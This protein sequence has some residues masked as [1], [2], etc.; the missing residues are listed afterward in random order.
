MGVTYRR[1]REEEIPATIDLFLTALTDYTRRHGLA[2]PSYT[3]AD[4]TP[5]YQ[6]LFSTGIFEVAEE[7]GRIVTICSAIVRDDLWFLSMFWALPELRG[8]GIGRPL[9]ERVFAEGKRRGAT[10]FSTWSSLDS[11]AVST[12]LKLGMFPGG[13]ILTFTGAPKQLPAPSAAVRLAPFEAD[14]ADRIDRA[15]RGATRPVDHAYFAAQGAR[16]FQVDAGRGPIGYFYV[17]GGVIG[18]AAWLE[19][20]HGR[21]VLS[22]ALAQASASDAEIK[23]IA[24]GVNE[25]AL[26][27][28]LECGL[29][30]TGSAQ[31]LRSEPFGEPD[32]YVPSGP[33]LF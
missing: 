24:L 27:V 1:V 19:P 14:V 10:R 20:E 17:K 29:R 18:P 22:H 6:H 26:R 21:A 28:A 30:L 32:R 33:G 8:R 9:L 5:L 3:P 4:I 12:Y 16:G 13:P 23:L 31:W 11:T 25:T 15:V 2:A 7:R